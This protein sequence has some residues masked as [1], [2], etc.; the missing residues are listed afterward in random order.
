MVSAVL[1][2]SILP[3]FKDLKASSAFSGSPPYILQLGNLCCTAKIVPA[4]NPPPPTGVKM[5]SRFEYF[6]NNSKAA[7][8]CPLITSKL[9]EG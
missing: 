6:S 5:A 1:L 4:T 8:P 9:L 7:V 3:D 2:V